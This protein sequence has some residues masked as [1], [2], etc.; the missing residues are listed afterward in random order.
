MVEK[1]IGDEK[2]WSKGKKILDVISSSKC[3]GLGLKMSISNWELKTRRVWCGI[4]HSC[5]YQVE[6][7]CL[8]HFGE[9]RSVK[10][11]P[12]WQREGIL[13]EL[14]QKVSELFTLISSEKAKKSAVTPP[15]Q[16]GSSIS[17]SRTYIQSFQRHFTSSSS[18]FREE[19]KVHCQ[20]TI[21]KRCEF[22]CL[23]SVEKDSVHRNID[24]VI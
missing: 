22:Q 3:W 19:R 18:T 9:K 24:S 20:R 8:H 13:K 7:Q 12:L 11:D 5:L 15:K 1:R 10:R 4:I 6:N 14:Q 21:H 16:E 2:R 17:S 23:H